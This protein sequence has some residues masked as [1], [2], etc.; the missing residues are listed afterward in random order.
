MTSE[1]LPHLPGHIPL[2]TGGAP[3]S[4]PLDTGCA[5]VPPTDPPADV[6][7]LARHDDSRRFLTGTL[8]EFQGMSRPLARRRP[9]AASVD[10]APTATVSSPTADAAAPFRWW[11]RP[12]RLQ[13]PL[14]GTTNPR[15]CGTSAP[16][17]RTH[18]EDLM[19][20]RTMAAIA[21]VIAVLLLLFL[22]VIPR[23]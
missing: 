4:A 16:R 13:R 3:T 20:T 2:G 12:G 11:R 5:P 8:G 10:K 18:P 15:G 21:L 17:L 23:M 6:S 1:P 9:H 22:V 19:N 7:V 14:R